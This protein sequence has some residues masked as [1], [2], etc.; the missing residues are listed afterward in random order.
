ANGSRVG[1]Y[2]DLAVSI[3]RNGAEAW[4]YQDC[5]ALDANVGAPPDAFNVSG[6]DWGIAPLIPHRLKDAGFAPF[7]AVLRANMRHAGALRIDHVMSLTRLFWIPPRAR[8]V[9]GAYVHYPVHDLIGI[10]ALESQRNRCIV[11]GEDLGTV[12]EELRGVLTDAG[13]FSYRVL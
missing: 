13:I 2:Q 7:I 4:A 1:L 8:P 10:V 5:Y 9:E 11:I 6:Q 3:D 12:P